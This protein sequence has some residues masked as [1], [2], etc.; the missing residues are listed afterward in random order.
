VSAECRRLRGPND[1]GPDCG[2]SGKSC[3]LDID[4]AATT[5]PWVEVTIRVPQEEFVHPD[6]VRGDVLGAMP[7]DG[8]TATVT[9][10]S[11]GY[12]ELADA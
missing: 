8:I 5:E 12:M 1:T 4:S 3:A 11:P 2:C 10:T 6:L 9:D 7:W